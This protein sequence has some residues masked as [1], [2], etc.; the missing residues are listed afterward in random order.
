MYKLYSPGR[1]R[2]ALTP[3]PHSA[4]KTVSSKTASPHSPSPAPLDERFRG[5][6]HALTAAR[7]SLSQGSSP[8]RASSS[9]ASA[10]FDWLLSLDGVA[11]P[12]AAAPGRARRGGAAKLASPSSRCWRPR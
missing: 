11:T 7:K 4:S 10:R 9:P 2:D 12:G 6:L 5:A 1:F 8:I 3:P